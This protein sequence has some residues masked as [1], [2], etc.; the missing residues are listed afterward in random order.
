M[1]CVADENISC[2]GQITRNFT[3]VIQKPGRAI[4]VADLHDADALLIR[5]VTSVNAELL[6]Y[7]PRL[8]FV[9]SVTSGIEHVDVN[10]LQQHGIEF[11]YAKGSN[12]NAVAQY[13]ISA[14][15]ALE[16][17]QKINL[18]SS[19]VGIVGVGEVGQ[20]LARYLSV[21]GAKVFCCDPPRAR[22]QGGSDF[23]DLDDI[24]GCDVVSFHVPLILQGSNRTYHLLDEKRIS[25]LSAQQLLINTA[26][27]SVWDNT[28]LLKRQLTPNRLQLV[29]DVWEHEP[30]I[31]RALLDQVE[32]ATPH[33]AGHSIEGKA[34]G[35]WMIY[36]ALCHFFQWPVTLRVTDLY[37]N[38]IIDA[39]KGL[40][41]HEL[42]K[43]VH[44]IQ[45][46]DM[47]LRARYHCPEDFDHLR[48]G[49]LFR[50]EFSACRVESL[51]NTFYQ[52]LGFTVAP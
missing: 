22:L 25:R 29:M 21:L 14:L 49:Y 18:A 13:V 10:L 41:L 43:L 45:Q 1:K 36:L 3:T 52:Q 5:S 7:A 4:C 24:L 51:E 30:D 26:R 8:R 9:G 23:Y 47:Q 28:A 38:Q 48:R 34:Q 19:C 6:A 2:L 37:P 20:R 50:R 32:I 42:V 17:R 46:D 39:P 27:G 35:S 15:L 11:Y 31:C 16:V 40:T 12:A 44:D 33:I